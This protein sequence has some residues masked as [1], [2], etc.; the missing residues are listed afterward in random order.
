LGQAAAEFST[1]LAYRI[2]SKDSVS[3]S[4]GQGSHQ[5]IAPLRQISV[6]YDRGLK[7]RLGLLR[8]LELTEH[9]ASIWFDGSQVTVLGG[10]ATAYLPRDWMWTFVA[11]EART[12]FYGTGTSWSPAASTKLSVPAWSRLRLDVGFGVGAENYSNIDQIGRISARTYMGG[13]H[14]R[15]NRLQD[16][17]VFVGYQQRS[18]GQ[19][20]T[21]I[22]GGYGFHF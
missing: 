22:G 14:Y 12:D 19:T 1:G 18:H 6:D 4:F 20:Q 7:L 16:F 21:S 3:F 11:N 8:G 13:A 2:A 17:L 10:I 15:V 5:Q 9:S